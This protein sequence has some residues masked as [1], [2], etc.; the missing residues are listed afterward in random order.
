[1]Q[2]VLFL[3][4][5]SSSSGHVPRSS[6][7]TPKFP[8]LPR[9]ALNIAQAEPLASQSSHT[10]NHLYYLSSPCDAQRRFI[11]RRTALKTSK[12]PRWFKKEPSEEKYVYVID[13]P[14]GTCHAC[15]TGTSETPTRRCHSW[16]LRLR[17]KLLPRLPLAHALSHLTTHERNH[18]V[19]NTACRGWS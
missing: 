9:V 3:T 4:T 5:L 12:G 16:H 13:I 14:N 19:I 8:T 6:L 11:K 17:Q 7:S 2:P 18:S 15:T 10:A 1:M